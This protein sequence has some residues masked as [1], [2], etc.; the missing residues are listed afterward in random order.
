MTNSLKHLLIGAGIAA[1]SHGAL[2]G[3]YNLNPQGNTNKF[4]YM[5]IPY[6]GEWVPP[7]DVW[8]VAGIPTAAYFL[9][10]KESKLKTAALGATLA[11]AAIWISVLVTRLI[12]RG[13]AM[14]VYSAR[15]G[16]SYAGPV[17]PQSS[18]YAPSASPQG[19]LVVGSKS[20]SAV[21]YK[22]NVSAP[23]CAGENANN[24]QLFV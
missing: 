19:Q 13:R 9:M 10:K 3:F 21:V 18:P 17:N 2:E 11:G 16:N 7:L 12:G 6:I 4:P 5:G 24:Q 15:A 1:V 22:P 20:G 23:A 14:G 8:L